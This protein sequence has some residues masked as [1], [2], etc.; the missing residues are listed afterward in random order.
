MN[1]KFLAIISFVCLFGKANAQR[2]PVLDAPII[3]QPWDNALIEPRVPQFMV[4]IWLRTGI[5][6]MPQSVNYNFYMRY[7]FEL[8]DMTENHLANPEDAF[9]SPAIRP[10]YVEDNILSPNLVYNLSKPPLQLGHRYAV[11]VTVSLPE[12]GDDTPFVFSNNGMSPVI[13][14][15]YG[16]TPGAEV[17]VQPPMDSV[18]VPTPII[19]ETNPQ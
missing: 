3:V 5:P 10:Y 11:R 15:T 7:R 4:F 9:A 6:P 12:F 13:E 16:E 2:G 17:L 14:F 19:I 8:V 18:T 1:Y